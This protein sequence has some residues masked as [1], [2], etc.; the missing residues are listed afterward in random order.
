MASDRNRRAGLSVANRSIVE[1]N[2]ARGIRFSTP[3]IAAKAVL[4]KRRDFLRLSASGSVAFA[5]SGIAPRAAGRPNVVII[6]ADDPGHGDVS[7]YGATKITTPNIDRLARQGRRFVNAHAPA[8]TCTSF[9]CALLTG[10]YAW[11]QKG[12][13]VLP[14]DARLIVEPGRTRGTLPAF[15]S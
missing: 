12:T 3:A 7:C 1:R 14:G 10:E 8:A 4:L 5:A 2:T 9:R 13:G 15:Y 11:Q 6:Y